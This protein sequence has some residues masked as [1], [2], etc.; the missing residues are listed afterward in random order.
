MENKTITVYAVLHNEERGDDALK[1]IASSPSAVE[2]WFEE[3]GVTPY[4][5]EHY[6]N[7]EE[8]EVE[9]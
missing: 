1:L 7:V 3:C 2:A 4:A 8:W 6:W 5:Q 9:L